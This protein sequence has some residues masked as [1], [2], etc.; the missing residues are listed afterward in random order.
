VAQNVAYRPDVHAGFK[1][2]GLEAVAERMGCA[3]AHRHRGPQRVAERVH[4]F[5]TKKKEGAQAV[6]PKSPLVS[7]AEFVHQPLIEHVA[8]QDLREF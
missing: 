6:A 7:V 8:H 3:C 2:M 1:Q 5:G 4:L